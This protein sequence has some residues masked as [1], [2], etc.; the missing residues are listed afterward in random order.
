MTFDMKTL[1]AG[2]DCP[3]CGKHHTGKLTDCRIGRGALDALP[4]LIRKFGGTNAFVL[5]D[6]DTH[7]A[8]GEAVLS[9]LENAGI[10]H[11]EHIITRTHPAPDERIVGEA[12]MHC[13][14]AC[15][16]VIAVGGGVINDTCKILAAA[17]KLPD[18]IVGTAPSMDGFASATSSMERDGLKV[19]L[20]SKCPDAVI[21]DTAILAK[22]P[23]HM[24][25]SGVGDMLA[26]YVS[27]V[28]WKIAHLL[29]G[30]YYCPAI[31]DLVKD[32]LDR[33]VKAAPAAVLGDEAACADVMEGLVLSGLAMNFAGLSRPASG[34]EH[35]ISHI[36][37]MRAL[38]FG[39]P[40]DLHGIQCGAATLYTIRAYETLKKQCPDREKALAYVKNFSRNDWFA[41]LRS[42]LGH[43]AEA[44]IAG[45]LKEKKYDPAKH[46]ARLEDILSHWDEILS[47]I[48][49]LP[50]SEEL[51]R[52]MKTIGHPTTGAE[53]GLSDDDMHEAFLMAK[54]IR[55]KYVLGRLLWDLGLLA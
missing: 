22:A 19:S 38:E 30:E 42:K 6:E 25:R 1:L 20:S 8:A 7:R 29:L 17:R 2:F 39:T 35:Y 24:I 9:I 3:A 43:G 41:Y 48:D 49:E 47:I 54:D 18:I 21:G 28:E 23:V 46:A 27:L 37:D 55:D 31:A 14:A 45:E 51:E 32:A 33:C 11:T 12:V 10:P 16:I 44:I 53:L 40:A 4:E 26:K 15:D 36:L 34:M 50:S 52:F 13:P 5:C